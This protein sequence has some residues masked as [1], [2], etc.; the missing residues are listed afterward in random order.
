M[1]RL[2]NGLVISLP[3]GRQTIAPQT[4]PSTVRRLIFRLA[5]CTTAS[6]LRWPSADTKVTITVELSTDGGATWELFV[7][8]TAEGGIRVRRDGNESLETTLARTLP[9]GSGFRVRVHLDVE[10][11]PLVTEASLDVD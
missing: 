6:P 8:G 9:A 3:S 10:N 7:G 11:G 2:V 4:V 1:P 5:R